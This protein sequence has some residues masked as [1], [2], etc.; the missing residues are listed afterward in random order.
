MPRSVFVGLIKLVCLLPLVDENQQATRCRWENCHCEASIADRR[1]FMLLAMLFN[2]GR[3]IKM[4]TDSQI[5][6]DVIQELTWNPSVTHEH[7]GVAVSG[8]IVTLSGTVPTYAEKSAAERATQRVGGVKAVV[9]KIDVK[10]PGSL[11]RTDQD[12]AKAIVDQ[13]KWT[14][15]VPEENVK[16]S[17]ENG[18]VRL[19]GEVEWQYQRSAAESAVRG[20]TGVRGI[21]NNI[22]IRPKVQPDD[23]KEKIEQAL[24]RA[25]ERE[26]RRIN[27]ETSGT[28]V[29]LSG[30]VR[31]FAEL[32]D[33][34]GAAWGA[35]G[36]T[37]VEDHLV[38]AA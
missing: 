2:C 29:V 19:K 22:V 24:K 35:P 5:Q 15:W 9:E 12:I 27:V 20:L 8:G 25:A 38:V 36:V 17:V 23:V 13:F 34:K 37:E 6:A 26:A 3:V 28:R 21:A 14:V 4:K 1:L 10:L 30:E 16:A 18:W 11:Q 7:I 33:A 31:S 32:R